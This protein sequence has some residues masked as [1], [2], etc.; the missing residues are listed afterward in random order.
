MAEKNES[1]AEKAAA[2]AKKAAKKA[3]AKKAAKKTPAKKAEKHETTDA[4]SPTDAVKPAKE[5]KQPPAGEYPEPIQP[6]MN[7][8]LVGHVDHGKTTLTERL[9]GKWTD[10]HSEEIKRGITI[11]LGYADT[12]FRKCPAC[13]G[14]AAYTTKKICPEHQCATEPIR[15]VSFVDAPGHESL[16]AIMLSGATIM[17]GAIL[18][19]AANETCPQPQTK[20]HLMALEISGIDKVVVVQNKVDVVSKERALRN[21]QQIKEFLKGS[22]YENA[23]I[24]PISAQRGVNIDVL[25]KVMLDLFTVP[26]RD[27]DADPLLVVARSFDVNKPGTDLEKLHGGVLGGAI[28]Q[29]RLRKGDRVEIRPGRIV[30]EAN[31]IKAK[32]LF[33][34]IDS[35]VTGGQ[36]VDEAVPG[37]SLAIMTT[38]DH[39]I[40]RSDSLT[41]SCVGLPGKLP[42]IWETLELDPH[43]LER[44]VGTAEELKVNPLLKNEI[45]MLNVSSAATV[46]IV[47]DVSKRRVSCKLKKPV[48]APVGARVAISRRV[49]TRFRLIGYGVILEQ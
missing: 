31:K 8:G 37:G 11:R 13:D 1:V 45:L 2:P 35:I 12:V 28:K 46:G 39:G 21:H 26:D 49:G 10:T 4:A 6:V 22:K 20:E 33:T 7:I 15:K 41:G 27:P 18:L 9:S 40:V 32:P 29:G 47:T 5:R 36:S 38:L 16:M 30:E 34:V 42:P 44:V 23:P 25:I 14:D 24:V 19:V 17:D 48:C 3:P 43:L